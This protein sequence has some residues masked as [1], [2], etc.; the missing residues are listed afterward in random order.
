MK[1]G[2]LKIAAFLFLLAASGGC[3]TT[4]PSRNANAAAYVETQKAQTAAPAE[5]QRP[6]RQ[7]KVKAK[8]KEST[9]RYCQG[10]DG[11][12][13]LVRA[14]T[15]GGNE[16]TQGR[17][18]SSLGS[19]VS[20]DEFVR[21]IDGKSVN[22]VQ[23]VKRDGA[24]Y[25][26][27]TQTISDADYRID[28]DKVKSY[29][30]GITITKIKDGKVVA[31]KEIDRLYSGVI[32]GKGYPGVIRGAMKGDAERIK[33]FI[34]EKSK[35][36]NYGQNGYI[37]AI[38]RDDLERVGTRQAVFTNSNW[39]W[40][41][42]FGGNSLFHFSFAGYY[43]VENG[44]RR[45]R[46]EPDEA[47]LRGQMWKRRVV[48]DTGAPVNGG[49]SA[50]EKVL[51]A[52]LESVVRK[53][54]SA[55]SD[56]RENEAFAAVRKLTAAD[57]STMVRQSTEMARQE[58]QQEFLGHYT[59][60]ILG[61]KES[62]IRPYSGSGLITSGS[63]SCK[64]MTRTVEISAKKSKPMPL[65]VK[66]RWSLQRTYE[67]LKIENDDT[68]HIERSYSLNVGNNYSVRDEVTYTCVITSGRFHHVAGS[69][70]GKMLNIFD[71][72]LSSGDL[73]LFTTLTKVNFGFDVISVEK[74]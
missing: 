22:L 60:K 49:H 43:E 42:Y 9:Q 25:V 63:G 4:S 12:W 61:K 73:D 21:R 37:Y 20:A 57:A 74:E 40:F 70:L 47:A 55:L 38:D 65:K 17:P 2:T 45:A 8:G 33:I 14:D 16:S 15:A 48:E 59:I 54:T 52:S 44:E 36:G 71:G 28:P 18:Q 11:E 10:D 72:G 1:H 53:G 35:E 64:D 32:D 50:V 39:G 6:C 58:A 19:F 68:L 30:A 31:Q 29:K 69:A 7:V 24:I 67:P 27:T 41:P 62:K 66:M 51:L 34:S 5:K 46:M 13:Q 3:V 26:L 56:S 23:F